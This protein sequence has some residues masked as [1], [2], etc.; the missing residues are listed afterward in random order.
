M[1]GGLDSVSSRGLYSSESN[2]YVKFVLALL[3]NK[4]PRI[5]YGDT[6]TALINRHIV[7][8]FKARFVDEPEGPSEYEK[9]DESFLNDVLK[10]DF[11]LSFFGNWIIQGAYECLNGFNVKTRKP[12][13]V[14][15]FTDRWIKTLNPVSLFIEDT[16]YLVEKTGHG[17]YEYIDDDDV[18]HTVTS[19]DLTTKSS[20][21][22]EFDD[23][24]TSQRHFELRTMKK[25]EINANMKSYGIK[26]TQ[27]PK[28]KMRY[29]LIKRLDEQPV[30]YAY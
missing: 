22:T 14:K 15:D 18:V 3:S 9:F 23:W 6:D 5:K 8:E 12:A 27:C 26:E 21:K 30:V 10:T 24:V 17:K 16:F 25:G 29:Y 11:V 2:W 28:G 1:T 19:S 7:I 4:L 13:E 20:V